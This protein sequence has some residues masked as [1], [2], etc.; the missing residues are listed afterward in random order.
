MRAMTGPTLPNICMPCNMQRMHTHQSDAAASPQSA[1]RRWRLEQG[2]TLK[3]LAPHLAIDVATLSR[4]ERGEI[5][6]PD[7]DVISRLKELSGGALHYENI[8]PE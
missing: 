7:P 6:R 1:L 5:K 3:A 8:V 2:M 4:L